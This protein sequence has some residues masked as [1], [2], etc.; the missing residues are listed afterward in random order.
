MGLTPPPRKSSNTHPVQPAST[1]HALSDANA[2]TQ[3]PVTTPVNI[4]ALEQELSS[5]P[6]RP[7]VLSLL[8][9]LRHGADIGYRGPRRDLI[10]PNLPSAR[11]FPE[12]IT[13]ALDKEVSLGRMAGP[14]HD[15]PYSPLHCS[16]L[17]SVEK[18]DGSRRMIMHLS[19]PRGRSVNDSIDR[20][21]FTLSYIT[22]DDAAALVARHGK[23]ALMS[24]VDLKSAFRLIPVR[25][26]DRALLGCFWQA[27]YYVDLQ[28]PFGLRSAPAIFNR[29]AD[30][31]E[32]ILVHN[33]GIEDLL[34]YLDDFFTCGPPSADPP[35]STAA[36]QKRTILTVFENL[37]IPVSDGADKVVGPATQLKMLGIILDSIA[38]TR[39]L[40]SDKLEALQAALHAWGQRAT[41]SKRELLSLVGSL[42]FAAKVVPPGRTFLRRLIDLSTTC[43]ALDGTLHLTPDAQDDISWWQKFLPTWPGRSL[44]PDLEWTR[45]PDFQ[46]FTDAAAA[47]G[48]GAFFKGHWIA[49]RWTPAQEQLSL[50]WK[51]LFPIAIAC[52]VWGPSWSQKKLLVHCDNAAVVDIM[53][54]GTC[55]DRHVM[56]LV[57][58]IFFSAA[59]GDFVIFVQHISGVDNSIAD[60]LSRLK[61]QRF[62]QLVPEADPYPTAMVQP[63]GWWAP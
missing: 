20:S 39:S 59:K 5:H 1:P 11:K 27:S 60:S 42:S 41:C 16:G 15:P 47:T 28:L 13:A 21:A 45:S 52:R 10:A 25:P 43:T 3:H 61:V 19:A 17:G 35:R 23:G 24:K 33:Y 12:H 31:L 9:S 2:L 32:Y 36:I 7:F 62:R 51:E 8:S 57:R 44:I 14:F 63:A 40:P 48:Y 26:N 56:A 18:S 6:D 58:D 22:L 38:W 30:A 49:H 53:A 29:L 37:G 34:H 54:S 55:R 46:L 4:D 50:T